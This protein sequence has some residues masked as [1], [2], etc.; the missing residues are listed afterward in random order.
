MPQYVLSPEANLFVYSLSFGL[1]LSLAP[2][3]IIFAMM[4]KWGTFLDINVVIDLFRSLHL[5]GDIL[6]HKIQ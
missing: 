3:L 5:S 4:F 1:L 2:G 6:K